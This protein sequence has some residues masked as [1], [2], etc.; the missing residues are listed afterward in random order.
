MLPSFE[1]SRL[2]TRIYEIV[3]GLLAW[4]L[5]FLPVVFIFIHPA[6]IAYTIIMFEL[7]WFFR[8]I[9]ISKHLIIGY[10][11]LRRSLDTDWFQKIKDDSLPYKEYTHVVVIPAY[12]EDE[13]V[14]RP[15]LEA[16]KKVKYKKE[17]IWVVLTIEERGG[18]A[19][20]VLGEKLNAEFHDAFGNFFLFFHPDNI[21]GE[22]KA[23]AGNITYAMKQV[24]KD[25]ESKGID[26]RQVIVTSI[27]SDAVVHPQLF[28]HL[29]FQF[30]TVDDPHTRLFQFIP[31]YHNNFWDAPGMSRVIAIGC[32]FW[33][34]IESTRQYRLRTFACY[35]MSL[36]NLKQSNYWDITS[37]IEDGVQYWRNIFALEGKAGYVVPVCT[38]VYMDAVMDDTLW[39]TLVAQYKQLRRWSWGSSDL[40]YI[41]PRFARMDCFSFREKFGHIFRLLENHVTWST[42]PLIL[43]FAGQLPI[44][45]QHFSQTVL[46]SNL[47]IVTSWI[48]TVTLAGIIVAIW[49]SALLLPE[50]TKQQK[51]T[52]WQHA[53]HLYPWALVPFITIIFGALPAL[54]SQTQLMLGKKMES[55][56]VTVKKRK[57]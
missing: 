26:D 25:L 44:L 24:C 53:L 7:Y 36:W 10:K 18:E 17:N 21:E 50:E 9:T 12:N 28:A 35:A 1:I 45:N 30:L 51:R 38:P 56:V 19:M 3:P 42:V 13:C 41:A 14:L 43:L 4:L 27:D 31:L 23:K 57:S 47:P 2:E 22:A 11:K 15:T 49:V 37:I 46:G 32:G 39:G 6:G 34:L 16:L 8:S 52:L 48:L 33:A 40:A 5:F 20:R 55:F 29:T 54:H